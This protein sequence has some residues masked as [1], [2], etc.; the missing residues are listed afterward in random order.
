MLGRVNEEQRWAWFLSRPRSMWQVI[1]HAVLGALAGYAT[2]LALGHGQGRA[3]SFAA[4]FG[5]TWLLLQ[6]WRLRQR[7]RAGRPAEP[8]PNLP[9]YGEQFPPAQ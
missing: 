9:P 3:L 8:A 7:D 5:G 1:L 4:V 2:I 6:S